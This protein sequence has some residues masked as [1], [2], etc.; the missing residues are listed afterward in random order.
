MIAKLTTAFLRS[1]STLRSARSG[2]AAVTFGVA[3]IPL[4]A[5]VGAAVDYSRAIE[6]KAKLQSALDVAVLAG[7]NA[8]S[9]KTTT[10]GN[11]FTANFSG[12]VAQNVSSSFTANA[13]GSLNGT[14]QA[15]VPTTVL[16]ILKVSAINVSASA[17]ATLGNSGSSSASSTVCLLLVDPT[18]GQSLLV[19]GGAKINAPDCEIDV[20]STA[21][22]A[23]IFNSGT[24][25][26]V[27]KICVAGSNVIMNGG[28]LSVV[29]TGCA[30]ISD[31]FAGKLPVVSAGSCT[32]SNQNYNGSSVTLN[33]GTYCGSINFNGSPTITFNPGLYVISGGTMTINSGA[34]ITGNGV[35][36]YFADQNSKIQFN[37]GITATLTAPT[38]GTYSGILMFEPSG[39][40]KSPLVFN[41]TKGETLQGLLYLPSREVTFNSTSTLTTEKITMVFATMIVNATDWNFQAGSTTMSRNTTT[42]GSPVPYLSN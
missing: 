22:P 3:L 42:S 37:G 10:A 20:R 1:A 29:E 28:T 36:F 31:P 25:L 2:S 27:K 4:A 21:N 16:A 38:S 19:N 15:A 33:P 7:V 30:A 23:A 32:V 11:A 13:D 41:G 24:T 34:T 26:N 17:K 35:T 6:V 12:S 18:A 5:G 9:G 39:L 40:A 8:T 14:A